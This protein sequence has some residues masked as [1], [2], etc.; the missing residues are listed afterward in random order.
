M[1]NF[2]RHIPSALIQVHL[3][4]VLIQQKRADEA[5]KILEALVSKAANTSSA[6]VA[7]KLLDT[8]RAPAR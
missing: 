8:L 2:L 7:R 4:T 6:Q 3:A 1:R 5:K